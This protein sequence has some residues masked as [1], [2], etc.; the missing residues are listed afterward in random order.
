MIK[1]RKEL[2]WPF[3]RIFEASFEMNPRARIKPVGIAK[4][5]RRGDARSRYP[6]L[7]RR[8]SQV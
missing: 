6:T 5:S 2:G 3:E 1:G 7:N 4:R 8:V